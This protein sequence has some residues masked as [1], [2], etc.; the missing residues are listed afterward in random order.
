MRST[1]EPGRGGPG[2]QR[3]PH[4][5]NAP[6]PRPPD[7]TP[8]CRSRDRQES[9]NTAPR[10]AQQVVAQP[11][12]PLCPSLLLVPAPARPSTDPCP[13][14][15]PDKGG[16]Q[17]GGR[18]RPRSRSSRDPPGCP[19]HV[20]GVTAVSGHADAGSCQASQAGQDPPQQLRR[21]PH[22]PRSVRSRS[23]RSR[24]AAD[25]ANGGDRLV[26]FPTRRVWPGFLR[27]DAAG[28]GRQGPLRCG[29]PDGLH[30]QPLL[31]MPIR[32]PQPGLAGLEAGRW[33]SPAWCA[34]CTTA[35]GTSA[36]RPLRLMPAG[37]RSP[38][39]PIR[40]ARS[41]HP[42]RAANTHADAFAGRAATLRRSPHHTT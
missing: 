37:S 11:S 17:A 23:A 19:R 21:Q 28:G 13:R 18:A 7:P 31:G 33:C 30:T 20:G 10:G 2:K 6:Q 8:R 1:L 3:D 41:A 25:R 29:N 26:L 38:L 32:V 9:H 22:R 36:A 27:D 16:E 14:P 40:S 12:H 15:V 34:A 39:S 35:S 4:A 42:S 5:P 24:S